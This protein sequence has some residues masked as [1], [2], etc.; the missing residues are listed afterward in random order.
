MSS[1]PIGFKLTCTVALFL[2]VLL[3]ACDKADDAPELPES[4]FSGYIDGMLYEGYGAAGQQ[5]DDSSFYHIYFD[6]RNMQ[7]APYHTFHLGIMNIPRRSGTYNVGAF[8]TDT[9]QALKSH[10]DMDEIRIHRLIESFRPLSTTTTPPPHLDI[11]FHEGRVTG[12]LNLSYYQWYPEV[13]RDSVRVVRD[14][15]FDLPITD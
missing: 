7:P 9:T 12:T 4:N 1:I 2:L 3:F 11:T 6:Q 13:N 5:R 14:L 10:L 15:V 8:I